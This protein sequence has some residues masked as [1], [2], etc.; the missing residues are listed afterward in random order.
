M[1]TN[2]TFR[3]VHRSFSPQC[4][5]SSCAT[6]K[7]CFFLLQ[8]PSNEETRLLST[9]ITFL[10]EQQY[11]LFF[12][13]PFFS[14]LFS[15]SFSSSFS[16]FGISSRKIE[17]FSSY[18]SSTRFTMFSF[19]FLLSGVELSGTNFPAFQVLHASVCA[20]NDVATRIVRCGYILRFREFDDDASKPLLS[21]R[22]RRRRRRRPRI[23]LN[24]VTRYE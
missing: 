4:S 2:F 23:N 14:S 19:G 11:P 12:F 24:N 9:M 15:S 13:F 1:F 22:R 7:R 18:F 20:R 6:V 16:S 21:V 17:F 8:F 10:D 5:S 3:K